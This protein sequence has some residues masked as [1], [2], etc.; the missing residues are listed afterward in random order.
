[1]KRTAFEL[2][3]NYNA[4]S[5]LLAGYSF[6]QLDSKEIFEAAEK[7][8]AIAL[9]VFELTGKWLGQGL[10]NTAHHL[11]PE[12][13]FLFGGPTAAG[14]YIFKPTIASMEANLL[15]TFKNKIQVLP[16]QLKRGDAPIVGASALVYKELEKM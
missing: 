8:D 7:G 3:A 14:D 5:S 6:D 2:M 1:M 11:S 13:I 4:S 10:A 12:A 15:A 9:E 16:S